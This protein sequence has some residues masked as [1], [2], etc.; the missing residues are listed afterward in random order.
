M[1]LNYFYSACADASGTLNTAL[2]E[3]GHARSLLPKLRQLSK[4]AD[5]K[6]AYNQWAQLLR[7]P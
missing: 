6:A 1:Y 2:P 3:W 5:E 7:N 4:T